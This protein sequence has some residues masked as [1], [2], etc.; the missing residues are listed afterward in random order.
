MH[1]TYVLTD[2]R[3]DE[4]FYVGKGCKNRI[5][6]HLRRAKLGNHRNQKLQNKILK[7]VSLGLLPTAE[8]IFEHEDETCCHWVEIFAIAFYGRQN[9]CNLTDGG[10]GTFNPDPETRNKRSD[11][12]KGKPKSDTHKANLRAAM[13]TSEYRDK[14]AASLIGTRPTGE[15]HPFY[16]K[17]RPEETKAKMVAGRLGYHHSEETKAKLRAAFSG[18]NG[19]WFGQKRPTETR[20]KMSLAQLGKI[21]SEKTKA[22]LSLIATGR[23]HTEETKAKLRVIRGTLEYKAAVSSRFKGKKLSDDVRE[24]LSN[25]HIGLRLSEETKAKCAAA[26]RAYWDQ[27]RRLAGTALLF[28][29]LLSAVSLFSQDLSYRVRTEILD[30]RNPITVNVSTH[31]VTT[32]QFP[33]QIQS[34][35]SD[36]FTQKPNEE[37]ADFYISP[38]LNWVSIRS[39]RPGAAQNLGVV[40][41]GRVYEIMI[42]TTALNDLAVLFRFDQVPPRPAKIAPRVLSPLTSNLP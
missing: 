9:L 27:K 2:P 5:H 10:D 36:G 26:R 21:L 39:L 14:H 33:A 24:K 17:A 19:Y 38:G 7:I 37:A 11:A 15:K 42:Q 25:G 3:N 13:A 30:Q 28:L 12:L 32:L 41:A 1:Y 18:E 16:G 34:L 4:V 40:I 22:K 29:S 8:K 6:V 35:E 20:R 31:A 23:I